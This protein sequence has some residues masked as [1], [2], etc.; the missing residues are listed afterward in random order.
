MKLKYLL[1]ICFLLILR[2]I[3][4][5][6][7]N[8]INNLYSVDNLLNESFTP[9]NNKLLVLG[10]NNFYEIIF[11]NK[12]QDQAYIVESLRKRFSEYNFI[13]GEDS[14]SIDFKI[15][16]SNSS[17][18]TKY[19]K[20]FVDNIFGT[21]KVEREVSVTYE[22]Q[23]TD[24]KDSSLIYS[25]KF[26]KKYKDNFDIDKLNLVEDNR[27]LFTQSILPDE[28]TVSQLFYPAII[29]AASAVAIILFFIIRSN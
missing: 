13:F 27:F 4:F 12:K 3:S 6:Q 2:G 25:Q 14:D 19:K 18:Y 21:K 1:C 11:D 24:K 16:F 23:I 17:I 5:C 29:I 22:L 20:I 8:I 26:D 9:L 15:I 7:E 10:K 28:N